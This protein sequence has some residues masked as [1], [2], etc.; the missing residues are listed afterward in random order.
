MQNENTP[1]EGQNFTKLEA[2]SALRGAACS[3]FLVICATDYEGDNVEAVFLDREKAKALRDKLNT[4][5]MSF[6]EY[7]AEEWSDGERSG[8]EI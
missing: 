1:T 4:R 2:E 7:R 8:D 5:K 6:Q 3:V